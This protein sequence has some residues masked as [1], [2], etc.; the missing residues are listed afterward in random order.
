MSLNRACSTGLILVRFRAKSCLAPD[1][2]GT[3]NLPLWRLFS[4]DH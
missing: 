1:N 4:A 3:G 2:S